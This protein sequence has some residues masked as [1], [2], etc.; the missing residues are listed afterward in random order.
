MDSIS[1]SARWIVVKVRLRICHRRAGADVIFDDATGRLLKQVG[2][3]EVHQSARQAPQTPVGE[4]G[5]SF[6]L[7]SHGSVWNSR[8]SSVSAS[9]KKLP[10]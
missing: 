4:A 3:L 8:H 10:P 5:M 7:A 2:A 9:E 1:E 6:A